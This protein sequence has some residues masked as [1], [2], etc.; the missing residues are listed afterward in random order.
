MRANALAALV[1][2]VIFG[3]VRGLT[4]EQSIVLTDWLPQLL[5]QQTAEVLKV[6]RIVEDAQYAD[7]ALA[8][9]RDGA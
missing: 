4:K 2:T 6:A 7:N 3:D 8:A 1:D 9:G 5:A